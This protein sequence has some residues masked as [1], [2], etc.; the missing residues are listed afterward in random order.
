MRNL[1][2]FSVLGLFMVPTAWAQFAPTTPGDILSQYHAAAA[3][4]ETTVFGYAQDLFYLLAVIELSWTFL[5]LFLQQADLQAWMFGFMRSIMAI[6]AFYAL[7]LYGNQWFPAVVNSF[8]QI[9]SLVAGIP[10]I[11]P[12]VVFTQGLKIAGAMLEAAMDSGFLLHIGSALTIILCALIILLCW[13]LVTLSLIITW[14][15]SYV[16]LGAAYIMLGFGGSR[17]TREYVNRYICL[18]ISVGLKILTIYAVISAGMILSGNWIT[19]AQQVKLT[20]FVTTAPVLVAFDVLIGTFIYSLLVWYLPRII[21]AVLGGSLSLGHNEVLAPVIIAGQMAAATAM[22]GVAV[23]G[24]GA[25]GGGAA[26]T[27]SWASNG[28]LNGASGTGAPGSPSDTDAGIRRLVEST[29]GK[30][31]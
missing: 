19:E 25:A 6:I 29:K 3:T 26:A 31:S 5:E 18:V 16:A 24:G 1:A 11:S 10:S 28:S 7:L 12:T 14:V 8:T 30:S 17:W 23:A 20:P 27:S 4:W 13:G 21:T 22:Q 9:G 2:I 15:E